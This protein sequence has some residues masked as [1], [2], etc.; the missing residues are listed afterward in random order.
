MLVL[1]LPSIARAGTYGEL[2]HFGATGAGHGQFKITSGTHAFGVDA[3]DNDVY[4]GD[5][6]KKGE[7]RVQELTASGAFIAQTAPFIA[8]NHDGI[9]GIAIDTALKRIYVLA[10]EKRGTELVIAPNAGAAGTLYAFSSEPTGEVLA[11]A[12]GTSAGVLTG[13]GMLA[14]QSDTPEAALL[15]PRG[16]TVDPTTHDVIVAGE[17]ELKPEE[18]K[19]PQLRVA[20]QRI[21]SDGAVGQ[22]YVDGTDALAS[23]EPNSPIVS[24]TGAVY[25]AIP[26][27]RALPPVEA[28]DE[29]MQ[30]P[31]NFA[32]TAP[33]TP[34]VAL[35]LQAPG[36]EGRPVVE[37]DDNEPT[38]HGGG[39]SLA[40]PAGGGSG[41]GTIYAK[42][43]VFVGNSIEGAYYPGVL[44]F[45]ASGGAEIGWT[46]GQ[47]KKTGTACALGFAGRTYSSVAAGADETVFVLDPGKESPPGPPHVVEFGPGGSGCPGA[48]A[49]EPV[50][51]VSGRPLTPGEAIASGTEVTLSS[52]V[53][54]AN[55]LSVEW[56]F[57]DGQSASVNTD[58]YAH[59]SVKHKFVQ[60]GELT[61]TETIHTDDLATPTI[62][63]TTKI[64]VSATAAPPTAVL[65]GPA[66]VTLGGAGGQRLVYSKDGG[67][68]LVSAP[69]QGEA[70]FDGS[71][72]HASTA[73]G[74]NRI[75]SYQWTFGDGHSE[76]TSSAT[77]QHTYAGV[78]TYTVA[79]TVTDTH[80]LASEPVTI[81]VRVKNPPE[82]LG[83]TG[84]Q[85]AGSSTAVTAATS[86]SGAGSPSPG[87]PSTGRGHAHSAVPAVTLHGR[88]LQV[89][90][91]GTITL[92]L[93]CPR[94]E[95]VCRGAVML[96]TLAAV[97][98]S[99]RGAHGGRHAR[100][101]ILILARGTVTIAGGHTRAIVLALT[102]D[103]RMLLGHAHRVRARAT[104]LARD[105]AG[106]THTTR[107]I[108][109][110]GA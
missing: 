34:F 31:S 12:G 65:E 45:A 60:G 82:S 15:E 14:P 97:R 104:I 33:P 2:A 83:L 4:V 87:G 29:L 105:S 73:Q 24:A 38:V 40:P 67:L 52:T 84:A 102:S 55:A 100:P 76:T 74:A 95:S 70:S 54:Q 63:K 27:A 13:P 71:A 6:V 50:S 28:A 96:Q 75:V 86:G 41:E 36:E 108:V 3:T 49:E 23:Q 35:A 25:L 53:T 107:T 1:A 8:P 7:Y 20:L 59:T 79:L 22:R 32:S 72:S 85:P 103:A 47:T 80:G 101:S 16:I 69:A 98:L 99:T 56:S 9:E 78:G 89:G 91:T 110:L 51:S 30:I 26:Q 58:E 61:V 42:A 109:T 90:R 10:L 37:F 92:Q 21:H 64:L 43:H 11:P 19:E 66:E 94:D 39:L 18:E 93:A 46:G 88:K 77:V 17:V 44:A 57:G 62:V 68:E 48:E 5:E 81:T 106:V